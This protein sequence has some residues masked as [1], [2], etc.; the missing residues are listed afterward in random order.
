METKPASPRTRWSRNR[1][2]AI[3]ARATSRSLNAKFALLGV[4]SPAKCRRNL[5]P[6]RGA[7]FRLSFGWSS[8]LAWREVYHICNSGTCD[9]AAYEKFGEDETGGL[10]R[11]GL[12]KKSQLKPR[13]RV[14]PLSARQSV[15]T[16]GAGRP[17]PA[18]TAFH[19]DGE[20]VAT[21]KSLQTKAE[22]A[23]GRLQLRQL[24]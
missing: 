3:R 21:P 12:S 23:F 4:G 13:G 15:W 1:T 14:S 7:S 18:G 2:S 24:G 5:F 16:N 8:I 9:G 11:R 10:H 20:D 6:T 19:P 17:W 22:A